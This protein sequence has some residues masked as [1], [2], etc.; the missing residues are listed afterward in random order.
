VSALDFVLSP[1]EVIIATDT[2]SRTKDGKSLNFVSKIFPLPHLKSVICGTGSLNLMVDWFSFVQRQVIGK[3][4]TILDKI[5]PTEL[6]KIFNKYEFDG[7]VTS[8]IYHFGYSK[9][10]NRFIGLAYRSTN[11]FV[12]E[13][14]S[15]GIGIKPYGEEIKDFTLQQQTKDKG[16]VDSLIEIMKKQREIDES[17]KLEENVGI[18]GEIHFLIL[19]ENMQVMWGCYTFSDYDKTFNQM[20]KNLEN[21]GGKIL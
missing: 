4:I 20:L 3:D 13:R 16:I 6:K 12:S 8:T 14:L 17:K 1:K 2:L 10:E 7:E 5:A 21:N 18:G 19:K 15:D 11:D 9:K